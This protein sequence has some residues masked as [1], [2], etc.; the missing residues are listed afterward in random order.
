MALNWDSIIG[1]IIILFLI[2]VVWARISKQTIGEVLGDIKE[3]LGDRGEDVE[4]KFGEII[5][6]E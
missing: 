6:Y 3:M 5:D 2:L 4:E 1:F